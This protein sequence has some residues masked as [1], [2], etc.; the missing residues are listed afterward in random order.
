[1]KECGLMENDMAMEYFLGVM[2]MVNI[3]DN[4]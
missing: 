2:E 4:G 1:M 3:W